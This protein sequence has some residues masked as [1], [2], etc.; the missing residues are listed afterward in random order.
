MRLFLFLFIFSFFQA[1]SLSTK[2]PY[3]SYEY[4]V[5]LCAIFQNEA[6]YLKEWI[7]FH[8]LVGVQHFYLYN[9]LSQDHFQQV[10]SPYIE[11]GEVELFEWADCRCEDGSCDWGRTQNSAF[12]HAIQLA[13]RKAKWLALLD[14]DEFLF[15]VEKESLVDFLLDYERQAALCVNWQM[16]GTSGVPEISYGHL[17]IEDL[18]YKAPADYGEN[19][20]IKSIVRPVCVESVGNPH[21]CNFLPGFYQVN[22][23][24]E[25]RFGPFSPILVDKI[26]INHYWTRDEKFFYERKIAR[27]QGWLD[28]GSI[29]RANNLNEVVDTS[30][31]K[32]VPKLREKL[33]P[34]YT[35]GR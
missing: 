11:S 30:I 27:R 19:V 4:D 26:R 16:Y 3:K 34:N 31:H 24:G 7:E 1:S 21:Y 33:Y 29:E 17:L 10:L 5:A 28:G 23:N 6:D 15:P 35:V 2:E 8:K 22:S 9:N 12:F 18:I 32:Y 25:L 20:H 14:T 13:K